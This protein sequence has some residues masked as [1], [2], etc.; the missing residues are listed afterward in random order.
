MLRR[1]ALALTAV[2]LA[3]TP[4]P[5][6]A[7]GQTRGASERRDVVRRPLRRDDHPD[8]VR[9]PAHRGAN[10]GG[11]GYGY[12]YAFAQDNICTMAETYVTVDAQRSRGS[13]PTPATRSAAT[14]S[15]VNNL[16]SDFFCK[17]IIDV[18]HRRQAARQA[19]AERA[20]SADRAGRRAATSPAT[21]ATSHDVGGANGVTDP[22]CR[23]KPWVRADH[24]GRRLPALLPA[25]RCSPARRRR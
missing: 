6:V 12:G 17:R 8:R 13:A 22:T 15:T 4:F 25:R 2:A 24:R 14:A 9:H 18:A 10:Y 11:L 21:T 19:A 7:G 20:R 23:G 1:L 16:D 3:A 5:A